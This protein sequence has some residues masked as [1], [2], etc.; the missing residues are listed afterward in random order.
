M[1]ES[2]FASPT[3]ALIF[4]V[5]CAAII[6]PTFDGRPDVGSVANA[7][8]SEPIRESLFSSRF[9]VLSSGPHDPTFG[10]SPSQLSGSSFASWRQKLL[11]RQQ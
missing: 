6:A 4:G 9:F 5:A 8:L 11:N 2:F 7:M 3:C 1:S 10:P